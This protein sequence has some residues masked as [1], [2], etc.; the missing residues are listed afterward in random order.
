MESKLEVFYSDDSNEKISFLQQAF[1]EL[2]FAFQNNKAPVIDLVLFK[3]LNRVLNDDYKKNPDLV[4]YSL[5]NI[6]L[7]TKNVSIQKK[8]ELI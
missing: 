1:S 2:F 4:M 8:L 7:I 6:H 3:A 5:K